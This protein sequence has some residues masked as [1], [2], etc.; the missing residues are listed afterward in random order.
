[1]LYITLV[2]FSGL[3]RSGTED[4]YTGAPFP[5]RRGS[6]PHRSF[7]FLTGAFYEILI[8][9]IA[10]RSSLEGQPLN[11]DMMIVALSLLGVLTMAGIIGSA[12][13]A[14]LSMNV[15][16]QVWLQTVRQRKLY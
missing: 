9:V 16:E 8:I 7:P 5:K 10:N 12:S 1:V 15:V 3:C 14:I 4:C 13:S 6:R 11:V 2:H